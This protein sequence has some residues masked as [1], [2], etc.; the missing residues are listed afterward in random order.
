MKKH[1]LLVDDDKNELDRFLDALRKLP[2]EDGFKCTFAPTAAHA[3]AMLKF[4]VPD[5]I[6]IGLNA[7]GI[8]GE[9]LISFL[10]RKPELKNTKLCFYMPHITVELQ[11]VAAGLGAECIRKTDSIHILVNELEP[12]LADSKKS[13][14]T[15][16]L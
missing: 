1:I 5:F 12:L 14:Y 6:F 15:A 8:A 13:I 2:A 3:I 7:P 16:I 11:K 10:M 4:L 9:E